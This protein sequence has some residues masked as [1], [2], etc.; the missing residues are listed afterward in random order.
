[1]TPARRIRHATPALLLWAGVGLVCG[2][3]VI[4]SLIG[5][6]TPAAWEMLGE[7]HVWAKHG[8]TATL[9]LVATLLAATLAIGPGIVLSR[10]RGVAFLAMLALAAATLAI[11]EAAWSYGM[12]E[13]WRQSIGTPAR[14]SWSDLAR[15]AMTTAL[16]VW[17]IPAGVLAVALAR[18]PADVLEAATLDG[19]RGRMVTRLVTPLLLAGAAAAFLLASRQVTAYDQSGIVT[20]GVLV[21]DAYLTAIGGSLARAGAATATGLPTIAAGI[22]AGLLGLWIARS[23]PAG[24]AWSTGAASRQGRGI[25]GPATVP[26]LLLIAAALTALLRTAGDVDVA[27]WFA[28]FGPQ[29]AAG[30]RLAGVATATVLVL[31]LLATLV[32]PRWVT[33]VAAVPF[34]LG[35]QLVALGLLRGLNEPPGPQPLGWI[36]DGLY[37]LA[38]DRPIGFGWPA[39][40]LFAWLGLAAAGATW[41][42]GLADLR[43]QADVDGAGRWTTASRV[44]WP[45]AWPGLL[46][47]MLG[48]FALSLAET[49]AAVLTYPDSI[50][51]T[52]M[53]NV[54]T[55]AYGPM[56]RAALLGAL[57]CA[58]VAVLTPMIWLTGRRGGRVAIVLLPLALMLSACDRPPP[59]LA[60]YAEPG[61]Q[62]GQLSTPRALAYAE[63]DDR[64]YTIDRTARIQAFDAGTGAFVT[65]WTTPEQRY[66][67]PTGVSVDAAGNVWVPDTH[68]NRVIVYRPDGSEWFRFGEPGEALG[69]FIW[70]TD[71]L[72][73]DDGRVLVSQ[74]GPGESG[75]ADRVQLFRHDG[76]G[77]V[78]VVRQIGSWGFGEGQ[79]RRPQSMAVVGQTLWVA[80]AAGHRLLAFDLS[81]GNEGAYLRAIGEGGASS[82]I[83]RFRFPYGLAVDGEEMLLVSEFGNN[84]VQRIDPETGESLGVWGTFGGR[85]GEVKYP[86]AVAY[87]ARRDRIVV[88]DSGNARLQVID[89]AALQLPDAEAGE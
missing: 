74:Y 53:S 83:G 10:G 11:P 60:I 19:A 66:G 16:Q 72:A 34:L 7:S 51:N 26:L 20:S 89:P 36:Q 12:A 21:R 35:G 76:Q 30:A 9:T 32:R 38:Y 46:A 63:A 71:V 42:G 40:A 39:A 3:P 14:D 55:L 79:F 77:E 28:E 64:L 48:V 65:G 67:R 81:P 18:V 15:A 17:P 44:I 1:M 69:Q 8:R 49:P 54:H 75:S 13:A 61:G 68:Y 80:D 33:L 6:A 78:E 25:A 27:G 24:D 70:P 4:W 84:R 88:A 85:P 86:W 56:A 41:R 29:I 22:M 37:E 52:M 59:P 73:L 62:P 57:V 5:L 31:T 2:L 43:D 58:G 87:D 47:A 82:Q 50:V 45:V 23:R